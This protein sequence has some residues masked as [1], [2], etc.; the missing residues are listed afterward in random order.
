MGTSSWAMSACISSS[1]PVSCRTCCSS[2]RRGCRR[3]HAHGSAARR[4][5]TLP[6]VRASRRGFVHRLAR[7]DSG[8]MLA[9][10]ARKGGHPRRADASPAQTGSRPVSSVRGGS[11]ESV[12]A[13]PRT[14]ITRKKAIWMIHPYGRMPPYSQ[15]PPDAYEP[16]ACLFC[17]HLPRGRSDSIRARLIRSNRLASSSSAA[18]SSPA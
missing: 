9:V 13:D 17:T 14:G 8:R 10:R 12:S 15:C 6:S 2:T 5:R 4:G 1:S 7:P 18:R 16:S 11:V 3:P